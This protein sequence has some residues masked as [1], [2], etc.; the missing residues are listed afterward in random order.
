MI[1]V[2][3]DVPLIH[4]EEFIVY[5]RFKLRECLHLPEGWGQ[6]AWFSYGKYLKKALAEEPPGI[7][8]LWV[9]ILQSIVSKDRF[10]IDKAIELVHG[11]L[12]EDEVLRL[13]GQA[14]CVIKCRNEGIEKLRCA[15][16]ISPSFENKKELAWRLCSNE[17]LYEKYMLCSE[18]LDICN[19]DCDLMQ[20]KAMV[21]MR[22]GRHEEAIS[23]LQGC[24]KICPNDYV[25]IELLAETYYYLGEYNLALLNY[26]KI[27]RSRGYMAKMARHTIACCYL[28]AGRYRKAKRL[29]KRIIK[30]RGHDEYLAKIIDEVDGKQKLGV[31]YYANNNVN[32]M[33]YPFLKIEADRESKAGIASLYYSA[34]LCVRHNDISYVEN[35]INQINGSL[36]KDVIL[37]VLGKA[38]YDIGLVDE[39][40]IDIR[41]AVDINSVIENKLC[42]AECLRE[43]DDCD[44][45]AKSLFEAILNEEPDN[46]IAVWSMGIISEDDEEALSCYVRAN[47]LRPDDWRMVYNIGISL[48]GLKKYD[49]A[50]EK[51]ESARKLCEN[52]NPSDISIGISECYLEMGK[53]Q[54]A[55]E[56]AERALVENPE[57]EEAK[58]L[59]AKIK[60]IMEKQK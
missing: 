27:P 5:K 56:S 40:I 8:V 3:E 13:T 39:G 2:Y 15:V 44:Q 49:D 52:E 26:N 7:N 36:P 10:F 14:L 29:A 47:K 11:N 4:K 28:F 18:L 33:V 45:E 41:K 12:P 43:R 24:I 25:A 46:Y 38:K 57:S 51:Y 55:L 1:L 58:N 48:A 20:H 53:F 32:N 21:L 50:I 59:I 30:K 22:Y 6:K 37:R 17:D 19:N 54:E 35:V 9:G 16:K 23:L 34:M 42:L 31:D 60:D